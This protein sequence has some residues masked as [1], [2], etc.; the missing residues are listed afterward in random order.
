MASL[1]I[2]LTGCGS[3]GNAPLVAGS[4]NADGG[5]LPDDGGQRDGGALPDGAGVC[6]S[7]DGGPPSS[8]PSLSTLSLFAGNPGHAGHDD[9]AGFPAS[10]NLPSGAAADGAGNLY[11]ADMHNHTIRKVVLATGTVSTL[12]GS[13]GVKGSADGI[14]SAARLSLP[15]A[16]AVDGAG[17]LFVADTG[18]STVRKIDLATGAVATLAGSVGQRGTADGTGDQ[19]QFSYMRGLAA[20]GAG[21]LYVADTGNDTIRRVVVSTAEVTT[22]AGSPGAPGNVDDTGTSARFN[23]PEGLALDGAGTLYVADNFNGKVRKVA[24]DTLV[25]T[26]T[27]VAG[28]GLSRPVGLVFDGAG[29]LYVTDD[30]MVSKVAVAT[31]AVSPIAGLADGW[32]SIDAEGAAARL[33]D[34]DG[35]A[36]DGAGTLYVVDTTNDTIRKVVAGTRS[37]TTFVGMTGTIGSADG[38][39]VPA[40]FT[41]PEAL[42]VDAAGNIYVADSSTVRV[43]SHATGA[44]I[45][46]AGGAS[47][48]SA[49]GT[50]AAAQFSFPTGIAIDCAGNLWVADTNN[51]TIRKLVIA[52]GVVST[53]AG[54][55]GAAGSDDGVDAAARFTSPWGVA[56]IG[57]DLFVTDHGN[58]TVR[59]IAMATGAVST[60]AGS[61]G[62]QGRDDGVGA[63]ARFANPLGLAADDAGNLY[64]AD[65]NLTIRKIVAA[66]AEVTTLAGSP[67]MSGSKDGTG[68]DARFD[69]PRDLAWDGAGNL[70]VSD[71]NNATVR[72]VAVSTG[73]VTTAVGVAGTHQLTLGPLPAGL[74]APA[75]LVVWPGH[76]LF[77][78]DDSQSVIVEVQ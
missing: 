53:L 19:A 24:L 64:V 68:G 56:V 15:T 69:Y 67:G 57:G 37:V 75:G 31:G 49:D 32:G 13:P 11:V 47:Y 35:I 54:V 30:Q 78:A 50:G 6:V 17:N 9:G 5:G 1:L 38:R 4:G 45:T 12:A 26:T 28:A 16:L 48:G 66:T 23:Q 36:M 74:Y 46:L 52:S 14:G 70:Y 20:D 71:Y 18:N 76:S 21:N 44:T 29:G 61:P 41:A 3:S 34:P 55:A 77:V 63:A 22:I 72:R 62:M 60:L 10:F 43:I 39:G 58:H 8:P 25:V 65:G 59:R 27:A 33:H 2:L 42:T 51:D 73:A 40:T 7:G